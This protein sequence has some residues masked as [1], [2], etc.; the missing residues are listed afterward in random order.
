MAL[1]RA[2]LPAS[3]VPVRAARARQRFLLRRGVTSIFIASARSTD[4]GNVSGPSSGMPAYFP[5]SAAGAVSAAGPGAGMAAGMAAGLTVAFSLE[6]TSRTIGFDEGG[7][8]S[9]AVATAVP[10]P[11]SAVSAPISAMNFAQVSGLVSWRTVMFQLFTT[12]RRL[13][14]RRLGVLLCL[15]GSTSHRTRSFR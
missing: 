4:L 9:R 1:R 13:R 11:T 12:A 5:E 14:L 3:P 8:A 7:G 10:K 15:C 2:A 6:R